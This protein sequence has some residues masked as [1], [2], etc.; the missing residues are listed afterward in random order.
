MRIPPNR[1]AAAVKIAKAAKNPFDKDARA[2]AAYEQAHLLA[3]EFGLAVNEVVWAIATFPDP[4]AKPRRLPSTPEPKERR[5]SNDR[6]WT[7]PDQ[8]SLL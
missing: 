4:D 1:L 8:G 6:L 7:P 2:K 5:R 3:G